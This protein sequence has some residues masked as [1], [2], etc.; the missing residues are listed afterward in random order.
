[1]AFVEEPL[2]L[3]V[4]GSGDAGSVTIE[5]F[6][7]DEIELETQANNNAFL[8]VSDVDYPGWTASID[9][10]DARVL[11]TD[12][13]LQGLPVPIGR[14]RVVLRY[15]PL[16]FYAGLAISLS[17]L[18][19]LAAFVVAARRTRVLAQRRGLVPITTQL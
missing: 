15:R 19:A 5:R 10:V 13:A 4:T 16:T 3:Q 9:G 1:M 11:R 2:Q 14:H 12:Y 17:A 7:D 8:V 18:T 6:H